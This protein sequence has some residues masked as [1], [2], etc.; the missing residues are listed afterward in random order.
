MIRRVRVSALL[1]AALAACA[2]SGENEQDLIHPK[3]TTPGSFVAASEEGTAGYRL[4]RVLRADVL[5][6]ER[7]IYLHLNLHQ[8]VASSFEEAEVLAKTRELSLLTPNALVILSDFVTREHKVVWFR[9]LTAKEQAYLATMRADA[10]R[11]VVVCSVVSMLAFAC[12]RRA[13]LFG[14]EEDARARERDSAVDRTPREPPIPDG[15]VPVLVEAGLELEAG[16]GCG[17][18]SVTCPSNVDFPCQRHAWYGKLIEL[19]RER[20]GCASGWLSIRLE[21][22]GCASELGMTEP[23]AAF[24]ACIVEELNRGACPCPPE[25]TNIYLGA[26]P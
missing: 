26:C 4:N 24:A 1:V 6:N 25:V 23:S 11:V 16:D 15:G 13:E 17:A 7:D 21:G 22:A 3:L 14:E 12:G 2:C 18:R 5:P 20:A 19:C 9:T 8:E 10:G